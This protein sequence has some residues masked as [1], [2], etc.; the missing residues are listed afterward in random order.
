MPNIDVYTNSL[1]DEQ[2]AMFEKEY[3]AKM[4]NPVLMFVITLLFGLIGVHKFI[5]GQ[6][7]MGIIY[8]CTAGLFG[9]GWFFDLFTIWGAIEKKN[10]ELARN[11]KIKIK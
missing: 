6:K 8:L 7:M 3:K 1:T 11:L 2:K 9:I 5:M 10:D 4:T